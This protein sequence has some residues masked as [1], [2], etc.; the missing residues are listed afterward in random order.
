MTYKK[1]N[2]ITGWAVCIIACIVYLLTKEKSASFWDCG[3]FLSGSYKLEVVHS[4][5]APLFLLIGRLFTMF[6]DGKNAAA[7]VNTLSALAS[8]FSVLFLFWS[9]THFAKRILEK[10]GSEIT[11]GNT[12]AIMIAGAIGGLAYTFSDTAWFSAVEGEVY[13]LSSF[14]TA[15]VFWA[16]LKWEDSL[17][18]A[19]GT[20]KKYADR[21]IILIAYIMGLSVGVHLLGLL[22]IPAIIMVYYFHSYKVTTKGAIIAFIIG[23]AIV[24]FVQYFIIQGVP[25][26]ASKLDLFFVNE[27]NMPFNVGAL[28]FFALFVTALI[29]LMRWAK[30]NGRYLLHL[31]VLSTL[32]ILIGYSSY[33]QVIIR[34]SA[35]V[36]IDMTNPDNAIS[37][38]SYLQRE[39]YGSMPL[40]TGPD[41]TIMDQLRDER[42]GVEMKGQ[43][44]E[45]RKGDKR[46]EE[47]G[48]SQ[49]E[50]DFAMSDKRFFPRIWDYN[51]PRHVQYYQ[52][53]LGLAKGEAP[54]SGDN[55]SF[56]F[57]YQVIQ[58]YWRYF[59]WNFVGR[60]NDIQ[61]I[62]G[63]PDAGN[64][65]SG[66]KPIDK[67]F[68]HG[69]TD[70]L[71]LGVANSK[72][73]NE[74][75]FLPFILGLLGLFFQ[76]NN[77]K[78]NTLI[79]TML[80]FFT[81]LAIVIYLNNV[82]L[83]PRERDYAYVGSF[84][85]FCIWIGLG[86]MQIYEWL[87]SKMGA[88][89]SAVTAGVVCAMVPA[90]MCAKEWDDHDR[91]NKT[92]PPASA[93]N[94]LES[95]DKNAILFTEGDNDTY[96]L[97]YLQEM[98]GVRTDVRVVNLSLLGIDWY[99]DQ[100][101]YK[102]NDADAVA[103]RWKPA[104]Y[105]GKSR[106][107]AQ[108]VDTKQVAPDA[109]VSLDDLL[110]Y[111]NDDS[112]LQGGR[113]GEDKSC[114]YPAKNVFIKTTATPGDTN[115][116][117]GVVQ[118]TLPDG[119]M[120]KN[121]MA[122][123]NIVSAN[124]G[125]RP[126]YFSNTIDPKHYEGLYEYMVQEGLIFKLG[127]KRTPGVTPGM[128]VPLNTDK[129]YDLFMKKFEFG[130]AN[131][132]DIFYDQTNRRMLNIIRS[133]AGRIADALIKEGK[134]EK[135]IEVLDYAMK[136]VNEESYPIALNN[137]D[138]NMLFFSDAY[139]RA[140]AKDKAKA[141][142]DRFV[143]YTKSTINYMNDLNSDDRAMVEADVRDQLQVL[144]F[145]AQ[146][147]AQTG[148]TT[149]AKEIQQK[150]A[151]L[152]GLG[153]IQPIRQ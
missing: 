7:A 79:V 117:A 101:N 132:K 107:Y 35:D 33:L 41:Y 69:D 14:L 153:Q 98:E 46:Y 146:S 38:V 133:A 29:F 53:Y 5:G 145:L 136:Q 51:D 21:W 126:I 67:I 23:C 68:G 102:I 137:E 4:P 37:L 103:M 26:M 105:R 83:Q 31:G 143:N 9:I 28:V 120:L 32:F 127:N 3:E 100:L 122:I 76:Y 150:V 123:L 135:A 97:W 1:I 84:Y 15:F 119:T 45:Y 47:L 110:D 66:I 88:M 20:N 57:N 49:G 58:M 13:A 65:L 50:Y 109:Y 73:R 138:R 144:P 152:A 115:K 82:P 74:L 34:S 131:R 43:K 55:F 44:M 96:P 124:F 61:N 151:E 89:P 86:A 30:Q 18:G 39:Q 42:R 85:A 147:A 48:M 52:S 75:Y 56:F 125:K 134:K 139:M 121:D 142:N 141:I 36:P 63:E 92:L 129:S 11:G 16:I 106:N 10:R 113:G 2:N 54:T 25:I 108:Y 8:G 90:I 118:F 114:I 64:W 19:D 94:F 12:I 149:Y 27:L 77:D 60:Q 104:T 87:R 40:L 128:P 112:K 95:C 17:N 80:F 6:S 71:P 91:S 70:K 62:S 130:G 59:M 148:D 81:G 93:K 72:A 99:I 140:G 22:V 116:N 24:G 111:I 78:R